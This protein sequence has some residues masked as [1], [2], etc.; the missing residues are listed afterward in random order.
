MSVWIYRAN[1]AGSHCTL[2]SIRIERM[3]KLRFQ[4]RFQKMFPTEDA[5]L[6]KSNFSV[7]IFV[8]TKSNENEFKTCKEITKVF[9]SSKSPAGVSQ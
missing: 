4:T 5:N 1:A 9:L 6:M 8:Q 7:D 3:V 2:D